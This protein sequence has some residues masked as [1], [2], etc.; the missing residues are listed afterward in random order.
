MKLNDLRPAAGSRRTSKRVGR[1]YGSGKGKTA[2]KGMMGQKARSGPN[3]YRTC[4]ICVGSRTAS[5][6]NTRP[7]MSAIWPK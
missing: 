2:G 6:W 3:P 7:L 4:P 1:G 5:V